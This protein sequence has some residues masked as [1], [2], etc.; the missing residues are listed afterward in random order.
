MLSKND[1]VDYVLGLRATPVADAGLAAALPG[2]FDDFDDFDDDGNAEALAPDPSDFARG[3][4]E[5][6]FGDA[7]EMP[8]GD[9]LVPRDDADQRRLDTHYAAGAHYWRKT[10]SR[11]FHVVLVRLKQ[12][13]S[14]V[15][16]GAHR[17]TVR[18]LK[19]IE[20]V[21][22][23]HLQDGLVW[24][25]R[26]GPRR[27]TEMP[28]GSQTETL[29][30]VSI[31]DDRP[32][33]EAR[34]LVCFGTKA[35]ETGAL[36]S[37]FLREEVLDWDPAL[38]REHLDSFYS[39]HLDPL[40][41]GEKWQNA[42]VT[43]AERKKARKLIDECSKLLPDRGQLEHATR[44]LLDEIAGS[45]GLRRKGGRKGH[46][47]VLHKLPA[48][49]SIA[50]DPAITRED[51]FKNDFQGVRIFDAGDKLLGYILYVVNG[52]GQAAELREQLEQ[53][54]FH[55][56]L[57]VY[58]DQQDTRFELWQG[59]TPLQ[60]SLR[61]DKR[62]S[63]FNG[64]GGVVQ[65]LSRFFIVSR[66]EIQDSKKLALEL[67]WRAQHLKTLAIDELHKETTRPDS[68]RPLRD[69]LDVFNQAL[70]NMDE[71][72][73]AD[74]YAQTI[75]YGMLSARWLSIEKEDIYFSRKN[76]EQL[77]PSTS[78][79][80]RALFVQLMNSRFDK[81]LAWLLDDVVSLVGRTSV[82]EVFRGEA[83]PS[84]HFY[85]D[86]LQEY[87][88]DLRARRGIFYTPEPVVR[89]M[90]RAA[91]QSLIEDFGLPLGLAS[92]ASWEDVSQAT[93]R[94]FD[95]PDGVDAADQFVRVLDPATGT[96]T[97]LVELIHLS[98]RVLTEEWANQGL[99]E[100]EI[101]ENWQRWV[102][103]HLLPN[104]V[105]YEVMMA[106]YTV[107]HL[108]VSFALAATGYTF[109]DGDR[110]QIYLT[111]TLEE[112][113]P[114]QLGMD[115]IAGSLAEEARSVD[116]V[117]HEQ[118]FTV[119]LGN[120]PYSNYSANL[121]DHA[122][123]LVDR[124][125][126]YGGIPIRE[127]NQLQFE[128][129]IQDD[130]VKFLA[131]A[132]GE[133]R[134]SGAG[135]LAF[136]TNAT[137][138]GSR[139]LRGMRESL[140]Q[141]FSSIRALHLHGGVNE[142]PPEVA[143]DENVFDIS[144]AVAIHL[145]SKNGEDN[146]PVRFS[147]LWG[148]REEKYQA[149]ESATLN[150][151][152]W[153]AFEA[154]QE[155]T[156]FLPPDELDEL[157]ATRVDEVFQ[158]FGAGIKTNRDKV[159]IA[160]D[161]PELMQQVESFSPEIAASSDSRKHV[162]PI[163]YRP[164]DHRVI[165]YHPEVVKSRSL[166]TMTHMMAGPNL[167]LIASSTWTTPSRFSVNCSTGLVEMKTGTHDR[168][169]TLFPLFRYERQLGETVR[170]PNLTN[171]FRHAWRSLT[172][173]SIGD[174]T[175]DNSITPKD[176]FH[177]MYA[178]FHAPC[179]RTALEARLARGFPILLF[180]ST[181]S[182]FDSL[183]HVGASLVGRHLGD[184]PPSSQKPSFGGDLQRGVE[185]AW[186]KSERVTFTKDGASW[187]SP[188]ESEVWETYIGGYPWC[189]KWFKSR[190]GRQLTVAERE[191][192]ARAVAVVSDTLALMKEVDGIVEAAGGLSGAFVTRS[193]KE[194]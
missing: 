192:L 162:Q 159:A 184:L 46:R 96:G 59:A 60:G 119:L 137:A 12:R 19:L 33:G 52:P 94:R 6:C 149:L 45:F 138:L 47:L 145:Y 136:I 93:N 120:P 23:R 26:G 30:V 80:L 157:E 100:P 182:V 17:R 170:V 8:V 83:D 126:T 58:P 116:K 110:L 76:L 51:D 183:A 115:G 1:F 127:R 190:R 44:E 148:N 139:S 5:R 193:E 164:F 178:L 29:Y 161:T 43:G 56:V 48:N 28:Q 91:H 16:N 81:N 21:L 25:E 95:R 132:E 130:F 11:P 99:S 156:A 173:L 180:P 175:S 114:Q 167:A 98:E 165:F 88:S 144:Q 113:N 61:G 186:L 143:K 131:V 57:V 176:L 7:P 85:Q 174:G 181:R 50:V 111:N 37:Y 135:V 166:P 20:D 31:T 70:A 141:T 66:T 125:R 188:V 122:R 121:S 32:D 179:Y 147:E 128:R 107:A 92:S 77:L 14:D 129:N 155:T 2:D 151:G 3:L 108:R 42:F 185:G 38:A 73:F 86:F 64:E 15:V 62:A 154:D 22:H 140:R 109:Q 169:T 65:L 194:S 24:F 36:E 105:G 97:Y 153:T 49:H 53:N 187:V 117:R 72:A 55:N 189:Q 150:S 102:S 54:H 146:A 75:T 134:R 35:T 82:T 68:Q 124:Y 152:N 63:Q 89:F 67:A 13:G 118:C 78:T 133:I 79:F 69:L 160:F 103:E 168:G 27:T 171:E 104:M 71:K 74:A 106:P 158:K 123:S 191:S 40:G 163:L 90:V 39:R 142:I 172:G 87:D 101:A 10:A 84:I 34:Q 4:L 18:E 41:Q 112:P 177:Y 9:I